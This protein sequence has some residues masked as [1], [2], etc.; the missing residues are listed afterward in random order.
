MTFY[1]N[2]SR[3]IVLTSC[4]LVTVGLSYWAVKKAARNRVYND[5][6]VVSEIFIYPIKSCLGVRV[7]EA[8]ITKT[9]LKCGPFR[10][11]GWIILDSHNT[12]VSIKQCKELVFIQ[13]KFD[14]DSM[15]LSSTKSNLDDLRVPVRS[16]LDVNDDILEFEVFGHPIKGIDCKVSEWLSSV[17]NLEGAKL[18]QYLDEFEPRPSRSKGKRNKAYEA[19]YPIVYQN[20]ST[21]MIATTSSLEDLNEKIAANSGLDC[22]L[23]MDRFRPNLV[24]ANTNCWAEDHWQNAKIGEDV[25][26]IQVQPCNRCFQTTVSRDDASRGREPLYTLRKF[27]LAVDAG[28]RRRLGDA[29]LFGA[30]F[31]TEVEGDVNVG[32]RV[33]AVDAR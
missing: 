11:R 7:K 24:I 23:P 6:G 14:G 15:V 28:D 10:D 29:P 30:I 8:L 9:G 33:F 25:E 5:V 17:L 16:Y 4:A 3:A 21:V 20:K 27:R 19:A 1:E 12:R 18:V 31:G 32:A 2:I 13:P 26:M 22:V